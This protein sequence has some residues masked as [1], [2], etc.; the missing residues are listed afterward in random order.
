MLFHWNDLEERTVRKNIKAQEV[1][2]PCGRNFVSQSCE[3]RSG[4]QGRGKVGTRP[5]FCSSCCSFL[6]LPSLRSVRL[7]WQQDNRVKT[8]QWWT[9]F[10]GLESV[11]WWLVHSPLQS[12]HVRLSLSPSHISLSSSCLFLPLVYSF[13]SS[14]SFRFLTHHSRKFISEGNQAHE[15]E[16][17]VVREG[18]E[19]R[20]WVWWRTKGQDSQ[21]SVPP[22]LSPICCFLHSL[23]L[24]PLIQQQIVDNKRVYWMNERKWMKWRE[25]TLPHRRA[26]SSH[27][28]FRSYV[29]TLT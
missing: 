12:S 24:V 22:L 13:T 6:T 20:S 7:G 26:R 10:K 11:R 2:E 18:N 4:T 15:C 19:P 17:D 8:S 28:L 5:S 1:I 23:H 9:E 21:G 27:I 25:W 16:R 14:G 29:R 3:Q